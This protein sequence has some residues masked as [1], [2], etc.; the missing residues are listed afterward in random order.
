MSWVSDSMIS[1]ALLAD[2]LGDDIVAQQA[3]CVGGVGQAAAAEIQ[4]VVG[5]ICT[6]VKI[7]LLLQEAGAQQMVDALEPAGG[8]ARRIGAA[9][10]ELGAQLLVVQDQSV[11]VVRHCDLDSPVALAKLLLIQAARRTP[12]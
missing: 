12:V 8:G 10:G 6:K 9:A 2:D 1:H 11:P 7:W 4:L 5:V 3:N